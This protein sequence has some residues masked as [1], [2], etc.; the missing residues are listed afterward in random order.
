MGGFNQPLLMVTN[1]IPY[2]SIYKYCFFSPKKIP[3]TVEIFRQ[4]YMFH[5]ISWGEILYVNSLYG[6]WNILFHSQYSH[7]E[8]LSMTK[9]NA[10][11]TQMKSQ[12][13]EIVWFSFEIKLENLRGHYMC[14]VPK[15]LILSSHLKYAHVHFVVML[16]FPHSDVCY[17]LDIN[18]YFNQTQ[19][20]THKAL[21]LME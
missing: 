21:S 10:P 8:L 13:Q 19:A 1:K 9:F 16:N 4:C 15:P 11:T 17:F 2:Y 18:F 3:S 5:S 12:N 14:T 6:Y 7:G 20:E